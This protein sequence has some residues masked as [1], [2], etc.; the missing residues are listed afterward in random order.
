MWVVLLRAG[1]DGRSV[2][3]ENGAEVVGSIL[4]VVR[5]ARAPRAW[6]GASAEL[7]DGTSLVAIGRRRRVRGG[8]EFVFDR[9]L[10]PGTRIRLAGRQRARMPEG[11]PGEQWF[12]R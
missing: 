1:G 11:R 5:M 2:Q 12:E 10:P 7:P 9:P 6:K 4:T 8:T 3:T